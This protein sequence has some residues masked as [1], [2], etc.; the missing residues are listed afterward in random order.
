M[1]GQAL[2]RRQCCCVRSSGS[3]HGYICKIAPL[4]P[5]RVNACL[6]MG[7]FH[8]HWPR[9]R[10]I[11]GETGDRRED[12][13][14]W[15]PGLW[16]GSEGFLVFFC[17]LKDNALT[18][19]ANGNP[20]YHKREKVAEWLRGAPWECGWAQRKVIAER[21]GAADA[22][23]RLL[24]PP[25]PLSGPRVGRGRGSQVQ[26]WAHGCLGAIPHPHPPDSGETLM[27]GHVAFGGR[28]HWAPQQR[29]LHD[30][31]LQTGLPEPLCKER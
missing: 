19:Q 7:R 5:R 11:P 25:S 24:S 13:L 29:Q 18:W 22:F 16:A 21:T 26:I 4:D 15:D 9:S 28:R 3:F 31:G 27:S 6:P 8:Q 20:K 10:V 12:H 2:A 23:Q 14:G 30:P 1:P 17:L